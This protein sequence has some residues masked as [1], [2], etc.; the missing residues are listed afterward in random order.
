MD[1]NLENRI[2][3]RAYELWNAHGGVHG[4]AD[5]HW[6]AAEREVLAA[7]EIT[8]EPAPQKREI[9][10]AS[11]TPLARTG[12]TKEAPAACTFEGSEE[13]LTRSTSPVGTSCSSVGLRPLI[14]RSVGA[15]TEPPL[16]RI[17]ISSRYGCRDPDP[18]PGTSLQARP[19][20]VSAAEMILLTAESADIA[21]AT[22]G[23][24]PQ[25]CVRR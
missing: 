4:Q 24:R 23:L 19:V 18:R 21:E 9:L 5:Q 6:F 1:H 8:H 14:S 22:R 13:P 20:W 16:A 12:P 7:A 17:H 2:R 15:S 11:T 10:A 25:E 3:E